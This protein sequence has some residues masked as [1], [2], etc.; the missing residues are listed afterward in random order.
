MALRG[1]AAWPAFLALAAAA[2]ERAPDEGAALP[3]TATD[4]AAQ[5]ACPAPPKQRVHIKGGVFLMGSDAVYADADTATSLAW[6]KAADSRH[7]IHGHTHQAAD[8]SLLETPHTL[9]Q[10]LS[11]WSLDHTPLR[12]QAMRLWAN[13]QTER[14]DL[15]PKE[16]ATRPLMR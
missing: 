1:R 3:Q 8:H 9:R 4:F 2:C 11:D 10:V 15:A 6:L 7:L 5:V 13:G 14:V 16:Q 12:A